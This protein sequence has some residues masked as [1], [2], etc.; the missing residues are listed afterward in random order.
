MEKANIKPWMRGVLL[1]AG[2]YNLAWGMF[3]SVF[4]ESFISWLSD[5]RIMAESDFLF[6]QARAVLVFGVFLIILGVKLQHWFRL[7]WLA[8]GLKLLGPVVTYY[9]LLGG[10]FSKKFIFHLV[11]NDLIWIIPLISIALLAGKSENRH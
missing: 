2:V 9:G 7:V 11:M 10:V 5:G 3:M 1:L 8:V 6:V 4:P